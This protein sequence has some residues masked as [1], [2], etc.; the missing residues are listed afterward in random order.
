MTATLYGIET[1]ARTRIGAIL[2]QDLVHLIDL[3]LMGKQAHWNLRGPQFQAIH[4][5]LDEIVIDLRAKSDEMAERIVSLDV[6]A[7]GRKS[8]VSAQSKLDA[9]PDGR[10]DG[11]KAAAVYAGRLDQAIQR[12]RAG[13]PELGE[14]DPVS[15]DLVIGTMASLE[16]HQWMLRSLTPTH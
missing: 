16:K 10:P 14:L 2:Q 5:K 1:D 15:E 7:D 3:A 8:A 12:M 9:F 4:E 6:A 11:L 13:L